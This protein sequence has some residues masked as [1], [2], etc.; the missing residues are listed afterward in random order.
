M[1]ADNTR[2]KAATGWAPQVSFEA[3]ITETVAWY[4]AQRKDRAA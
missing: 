4:R 2:L 1:E 3:G